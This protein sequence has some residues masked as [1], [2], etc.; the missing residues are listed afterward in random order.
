MWHGCDLYVSPRR[1]RNG[2]LLDGVLPG[3]MAGHMDGVLPGHIDGVLPGHMDMA[4]YSRQ[5]A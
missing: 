5:K 3:H 1:N 4:G 2:R